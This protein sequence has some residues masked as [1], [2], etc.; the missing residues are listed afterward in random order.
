MFMVLYVGSTRFVIEFD[1]QPDGDPIVSAESA[2]P[3]SMDPVFVFEG[4]GPGYHRYELAYSGASGRASL[5]V[6]GV[7]RVRNLPSEVWDWKWGGNWGATQGA[8]SEANWSSVTFAI[9]PEPSCLALFGCG[10]LLLCARC[11]RAIAAR[12]SSAACGRSGGLAFQPAQS[13]AEA[14]ACRQAGSHSKRWAM[15]AR[16]ADAAAFGVPA[17]SLAG[18]RGFIGALPRVRSVRLA[19]PN[20]VAESQVSNIASSSTCSTLSAVTDVVFIFDNTTSRSRLLASCLPSE[21]AFLRRWAK[22]SPRQVR[23]PTTGWLCSRRTTI[24]SVSA[25]SLQRTTAARS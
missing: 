12:Q 23:H 22:S 10:G 9:V 15:A 25:S 6:D 21:T 1:Q 24:R 16:P 11:L 19:A 14:P 5:W 8:P 4:G 7:E 20:G 13:G 2:L 3:Y 18:G 17:R